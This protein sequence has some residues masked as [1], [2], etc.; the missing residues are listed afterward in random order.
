[1]LSYKHPG[2][3]WCDMVLVHV[4]TTCKPLRRLLPTFFKR[5]NATRSKRVTNPQ[6]MLPVACSNVAAVL[7]DIV[8]SAGVV[9]DETKVLVF[10]E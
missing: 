4:D 10:T 3:S 9:S 7:G 2:L 5:G 8:S 6:L 1:M